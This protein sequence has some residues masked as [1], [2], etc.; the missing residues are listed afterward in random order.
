MDDPLIKKHLT[1]YLQNTE[2]WLRENTIVFVIP[3]K[4]ILGYF[5]KTHLNPTSYHYP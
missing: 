1:D 2:I 4:P 5:L 3:H